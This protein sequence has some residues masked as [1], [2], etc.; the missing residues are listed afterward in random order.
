MTIRT[1]R[2]LTPADAESYRALRL[3]GIR[4]APG[5]FW[6]SYE[7]ESAVPIETMQQRLAQT[8]FQIALGYFHGA[9]LVGMA[10]L[11]REPIAKVHHRAQL[12]GVYVSPAARGGGVARQLVE[13]LIAHARAIPELVQMTL[14]VQTSN[15]VAKGLY[16]R[17]GFVTMGV[18]R[19]S[20]RIDGEFHDEARMVLYFDQ[21]ETQS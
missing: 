3:E 6:A 10:A 20:T 17:L 12:W 2:T 5:A 15:A 18:E 14:N 13:A 21:Q 9:Q 1:I 19:R 4:A 7:E 11:K 8:R 16:E